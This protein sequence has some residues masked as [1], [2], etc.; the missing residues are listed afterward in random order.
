M[1]G[2]LATIVCFSFRFRPL[3][4]STGTSGP[5]DLPSRAL[6]PVFLQVFNGWARRGPSSRRR[7]GLKC[8]A[9]QITLDSCLAGSH[10]QSDTN[11]IVPSGL[12]VM[13]LGIGT[14]SEPPTEITRAS[15]AARRSFERSDWQLTSCPAGFADAPRLEHCHDRIIRTSA[16]NARGRAGTG[17]HSGVTLNLVADG[18][19]RKIS[20]L[21]VHQLKPESLVRRPN[22]GLAEQRG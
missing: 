11:G 7:N 9:A 13:E 17:N 18:T 6:F 3:D 19:N 14:L 1:T 10:L 5:P 21:H 12:L 20:P 15:R 4:A 16:T 8:R 22:R 2:F